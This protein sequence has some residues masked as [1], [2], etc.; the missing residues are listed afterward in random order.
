MKGDS[1][2]KRMLALILALV[3]TMALVACGGDKSTTSTPATPDKSTTT[4]TNEPAKPSEPATPAEPEKPAEDPDAWKYGGDLIIGTSNAWSVID[5]HQSTASVGDCLIANHIF[6]NLAMLDQ[7]GKFYGQVMDIEESADG[8]TVK[9]TL[10]DRYFSNGE[11][12]E[13]EDVVASLERAAAVETNA[14]WDKLW[15]GTAMKVDGNSITFTMEPYNINFLNS[16]CSSGSYY[17]VMPKEICDKYPVT[18]GEKQSNG[19]VKGG[20]AEK[21]MVIR[22]SSVPVLM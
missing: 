14:N 10:R 13:M 5:P 16:L 22:N 20:T 2:M 11:K 18:G 15:L 17:K 4:G 3:M 21:I 9:F 6:E 1:K 7:N 8:K 19:L 12:I